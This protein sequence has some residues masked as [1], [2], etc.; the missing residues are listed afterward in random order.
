[1]VSGRQIKAW[2]QRVHDQLTDAADDARREV[3]IDGYAPTAMRVYGASSASM[4]AI[5]RSLHRETKTSEPAEV[6]A[7][8]RAL[9]DG[10]TMEGRLVGYLLVERDRRAL[11]ALD[12]RT[13]E[14]LGRGMDSWVTVDTFCC[15][16]A[17]KAWNARR[18]GDATIERWA[19]SKDRWWRRAALASTVPLNQKSRGGKGDVT[20]TLA[21][22]TMLVTDHD[23]MVVKAMSWALRSL[24]QHDKARVAAFLREHEAS[25]HRRV[26][27]EVTTKL[28]TGR[29][30]PRR[31]S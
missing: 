4:H 10:G 1:M 8:A 14:A 6:I 27:R 29:K 2:C 16:L 28:T 15:C 5:V 30:T 24:I 9:V 21:I 26:I 18:I 12:P 11:A 7:V 22:C 31:K 3:L 17:G 19:R 23:D 25:L 13:L 20:R